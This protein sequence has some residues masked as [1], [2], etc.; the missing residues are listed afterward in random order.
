MGP[1]ILYVVDKEDN[2][3]C[4]NR[5][6]ELEKRIDHLRVVG[7]DR[8]SRSAHDEWRTLFPQFDIVHFSFSS[9]LY[10]CR[11]MIEGLLKT[12][13]VIGSAI[14][15]R[16][17]GCE[18]TR[19][20]HEVNSVIELFKKMDHV[21]ALSPALECTCREE[22]IKRVTYIPNG[23]DKTRFRPRSFRVGHV[24][25]INTGETGHKGG[26]YVVEACKRLGWQFVHGGQ[27]KVDQKPHSAMPDYYK[28]IDVLV[29]PSL[30]EGCSNPILESLACGVR[31]ICTR[32][33]VID[34]LIPLVTLCTRDVEDIM[35]KL[36]TS[37]NIHTWDEIA[38]QYRS[39][40]E[41]V[42]R[43][44]TKRIL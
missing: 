2:W 15:H 41:Q 25:P 29:Q 42:A 43:E 40:Y 4:H 16:W 3:S 28:S 18:I 9:G 13:I 19:Y 30:S 20:A 17:Y 1:R 24:G 8:L 7:W 31:V 5:G 27:Y 11:G 33:A 26:W 23:V 35:N 14:G 22:G 36:D 39:L 37:R 44:S 32:E 38:N 21:V 34:S 6:K 12:H 10:E